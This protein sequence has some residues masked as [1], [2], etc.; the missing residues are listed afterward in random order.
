MKQKLLFILIIISGFWSCDQDTEPEF[1][2]IPELT[3]KEFNF[4]RE[5]NNGII[6][7]SYTL[8]FEYID[9]DGDIGMLDEQEWISIEDS[10]KHVLFVDYFE[11]D[12]NGIFKRK[13][14]ALGADTTAKKYR[15][16]SITPPGNNKAIKGEMEV[17]VLP[18]PV[19]L[20]TTKVLKYTMYIYDRAMNKSN[21]I[22]SPE[23]TYETQKR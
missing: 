1:S 3:F 6:E 21:I 16:P 5:D 4:N 13:A 12:K 17:K 20:D 15:L 11:K 19:P 7:D 9:G 10:I 2:V 14:C 23:I 22:E 18:C 8:V